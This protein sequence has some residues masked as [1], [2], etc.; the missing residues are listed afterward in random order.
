[1]VVSAVIFFMVMPA[2]KEPKSGQH[3]Q[4]STNDSNP[5]APAL[6]EVPVLDAMYLLGKSA[7]ERYHA[8]L[9][10]GIRKDKQQLHRNGLR[11]IQ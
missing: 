10:D 5:F 7:G 4:N 8:H 9:S 6:A 11:P 1:M 3:H 2:E